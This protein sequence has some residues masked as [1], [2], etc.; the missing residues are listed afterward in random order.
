MSS[1]PM[2]DFGFGIAWKTL[3]VER[4]EGYYTSV[5][6]YHRHDFYEINLILSGNIKILLKDRFEE[7]R[8]CRMVLTGPKTPHYISCKPDTLYRRLYL[9]FS[10]SFIENC[11]PEWRQLSDIFGENGNI[12]SLTDR[13]TVFFEN[14]I[15]QIENEPQIFGQ[16]LLIYYL[17]L[18]ISEIS[19]SEHASK[20][21]TPSYVFKALTYL[22]GHCAESI[23]FT[24]L[25]RELCVGRT[26]LMT[27]F[28]RHIGCTPGEYL[29]RCRLKKAISYLSDGAT[30]EY[31][32]EKCGFADSSGLTRAFKRLYGV[33]PHQYITKGR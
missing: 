21:P 3:H 22:E 14:L 19:K 5:T 12:V 17:L 13:E 9:V 23:N 1:N 24:S 10:R 30:V 26:T 31:T 4:R 28:K 11:F 32:A 33:T 25:S 15:T 27:E 8:E 7:G 16:R 29:C 6:D 18:K 20:N 2:Y